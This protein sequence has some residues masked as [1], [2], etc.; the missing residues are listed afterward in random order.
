MKD[1]VR[2]DGLC[3]SRR[4]CLFC[5]QQISLECFKLGTELGKCAC[6]KAKFKDQIG[7]TCRGTTESYSK[8]WLEWRGGIEIGKRS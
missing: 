7:P 2:T 8:Y 1:G 4:Y 6:L 5:W 3:L